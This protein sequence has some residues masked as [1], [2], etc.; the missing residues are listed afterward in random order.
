[1]ALAA[2]SFAYDRDTGAIRHVLIRRSSRLCVVLA[3]LC[4]LHLLAILSLL[5]VLVAAWTLSGLLWEFGAVVEDGFELIGVE[6]IQTEIILGL[7]LALLPIPAA[8]AF[9]LLVSVLAQNAVQAV[10]TAMG[11][12]LAL[13]IFKTLLGNISHYIYVSYQP[14]LIDQSYLKEVSRL[15][16]GYSDVLIDERVLNLNLWVPIPEMLVL[17][18][19]ALFFVRRRNI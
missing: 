15:V 19:L 12:T 8:I 4:Y 16:R 11:I 2:Y 7:Q 3:K 9:G 1:V 13:D 10:S 18:G 6:E 17:V 14:S 5:L